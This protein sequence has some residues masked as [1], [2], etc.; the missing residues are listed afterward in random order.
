MPLMDP[1]AIRQ[2][3]KIFRDFAIVAIGSF[4]CIY[5]TVAVPNPS[6]VI[7]GGGLLLLGLPP[8]L[9]LDEYIGRRKS[10]EDRP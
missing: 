6:E 2:W 3:Q 4:M 5:E 7:V 9:R 8:A 1:S 10:D